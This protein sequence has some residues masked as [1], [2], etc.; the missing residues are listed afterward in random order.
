MFSLCSPRGPTH[1]PPA[2]SLLTAGVG[3]FATFCDQIAALLSM[4][5]RDI[6]GGAVWV[7]GGGRGVRGTSYR[8]TDSHPHTPAVFLLTAGGGGARVGYLPCGILACGPNRHWVRPLTSIPSHSTAPP[9]V[10][11]LFRQCRRVGPVPHLSMSSQC[12]ISIR[13]GCQGSR[14]PLEVPSFG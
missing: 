6:Q 14:Q 7:R 3:I 2:I 9:P 13:P 10:P 1:R 4:L 5:Q 8:L 12:R 11:Q